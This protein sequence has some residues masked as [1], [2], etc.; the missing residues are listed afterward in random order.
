MVLSTQ[1]AP[2]I[3]LMMLIHQT[4]QL[5]KACERFQTNRK[6]FIYANNRF[7]L[8]TSLHDDISS[9]TRGA[10][11]ENA[12][13]FISLAALFWSLGGLLYLYWITTPQPKKFMPLVIRESDSEA[14]RLAA[15]ER[16]QTQFIPTDTQ[17]LCGVP[18]PLSDW[19]LDANL[20]K[21]LVRPG[22]VRSIQR[23]VLH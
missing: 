7:T 3:S 16:W 17:V 18:A 9:K 5:A 20:S 1:G 23:R 11:A 13:R 6:S 14:S 15:I 10:V 22:F 4:R 8:M 21:I 2:R 19:K 12:I